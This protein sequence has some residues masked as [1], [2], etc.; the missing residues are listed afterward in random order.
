ML[1]ESS[2]YDPS[3][4]DR[5]WIGNDDVV[6][7]KPTVQFTHIVSILSPA[8]TLAWPGVKYLRMDMIDGDR[9]VKHMLLRKWQ[10]ASDWIT[11]AMKDPKALV[12]VHCAYGRSRSASLVIYHM[13][14]R[15]H[16]SFRFALKLLRVCRP[17]VDPNAVYVETLSQWGNSF[18]PRKDWFLPLRDFLTRDHIGQ[19]SNELIRIISEYCGPLFAR[20]ASSRLLQTLVLRFE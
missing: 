8:S 3:P 20:R 4:I 9:K 17:C 10:H 15:T 7:E 13:M 1:D 12:L 19:L 16:M 2:S 14:R 5:L 18:G 6:S 11:D